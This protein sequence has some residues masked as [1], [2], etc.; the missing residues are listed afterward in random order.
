MG[1]GPSYMGPP[2][3]PLGRGAYMGPQGGGTYTGP[4][5]GSG[6]TYLDPQP[7]A[8]AG[9][10]FA[11]ERGASA[12]IADEL[13]ET[14]SGSPQPRSENGAIADTN[15]ADISAQSLRIRGIYT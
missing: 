5:G 13:V 7:G 3:I 4:Q 12:P 2:Q 8:G 10:A 11:D 9:G 1:G 14:Q 15:S 6:G